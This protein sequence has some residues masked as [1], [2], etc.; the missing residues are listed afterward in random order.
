MGLASESV[1]VDA[2]KLAVMFVTDTP[3]AVDA[4]ERS[5]LW[6]ICAKPGPSYWPAGS[7]TATLSTTLVRGMP[8]SPVQLPGSGTSCRKLPLAALVRCGS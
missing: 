7:C 1:P 2:A 6:M 8:M 4:P 5:A 3:V